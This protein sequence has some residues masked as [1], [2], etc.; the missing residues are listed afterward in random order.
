MARHTGGGTRPPEGSQQV[1]ASRKTRERE[2]ESAART[3][4]T[5]AGLGFGGGRLH[6][7]VA[8]RG[9]EQCRKVDN[10]EKFSCDE[11]ERGGELEEEFQ[12]SRSSSK[13]ACRREGHLASD[14]AQY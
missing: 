12:G 9:G 1:P 2:T 7:T 5:S 13:S 6:N 8:G 10:L 4:G 14:H 11:E 3:L